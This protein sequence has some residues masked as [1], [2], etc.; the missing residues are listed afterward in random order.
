MHSAQAM[1]FHH[2]YDAT[3]PP[4]QGAIS[5]D[6]LSAIIE[7][8]GVERILPAAEW[9]WRARQHTL[10]PHHVCLSF[11][12]GLRCQYDIAL[13]VL[14]HYGLTAFWFVYSS[15]LD[16]AIERLEWY[17]YFRVTQ[18]TAI[19]DFYV[20][21]KQQLLGLPNSAQLLQQ[22]KYFSAA[23]YLSEAPFYSTSDREFRYIRDEILGPERY[24]AVMDQWLEQ[25][26]CAMQPIADKLWLSVA[27][28]QQ[29]HSQGHVIGLHSHTHP[30]RMARLA[31][32]VQQQEYVMNFERLRAVLHTAP[33]VMSHPC[34]S[35]NS[36]TL[37]ILR[38][39][40]IQ[41]G[42]CANPYTSQTSRYE[43]PREDHANTVRQLYRAYFKMR[44]L[45]DKSRD[46]P[47]IDDRQKINFRSVTQGENR[48]SPL[49]EPHR[50]KNTAKCKKRMLKWNGPI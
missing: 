46:I 21:F 28:V 4:G 36:D 25:V 11:D 22:L 12:D 45:I 9:L 26:P 3:H 32:R 18:F 39:L 20:A 33:Q 43:Y 1:M 13:P 31:R 17:R 7:Y 24:F 16:G 47:C 49:E 5:A 10:A 40:S 30:T 41:L 29:L 23:S 48:D 37:D 2:F 35:Y 38:E 14:Q 42:F 44:T 27:Q 34:N 8:I 15:V 6:T 50:E 19:D